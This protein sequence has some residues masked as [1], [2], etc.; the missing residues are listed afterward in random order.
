M[1]NPENDTDLIFRAQLHILG[2]EGA[3]W[4]P[5]TF[6]IEILTVDR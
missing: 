4:S 6:P 5:N 2:V 1:S 3:A